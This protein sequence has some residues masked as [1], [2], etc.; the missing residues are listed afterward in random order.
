MSM[1][2]ITDKV[3]LGDLISAKDEDYLLENN[4]KSVLSC[5]GTFSPKYQNELIQHKILDIKDSENTNIIQYFKEALKFIDA[6]EK[7]LVHCLGGISRSPTLVIAYFMWKNKMT[8]EES[9]QMVIDH[10]LCGPNL[11][12]K[13]QLV[14][15]QDKLKESDYDLD[16]IDFQNIEWPPKK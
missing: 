12:F 6:S 7:V 14:I 8:Y 10:R 13:K 1:D 11:G 2:K 3:F 16:K 15:F 9:F 5:N 4:I